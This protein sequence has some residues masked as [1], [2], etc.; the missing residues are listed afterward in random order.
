[1]SLARACGPG[2]RGSYGSL[3][4]AGRRSLAHLHR[5]A[6]NIAVFRPF[7]FLRVGVDFREQKP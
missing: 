2:Y 7:T 1:M 3:V 6:G 4:G 5:R